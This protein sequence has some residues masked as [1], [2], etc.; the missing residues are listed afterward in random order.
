MNSWAWLLVELLSVLVFAQTVIWL[1]NAKYRGPRGRLRIRQILSR[2]KLEANGFNVGQ[3]QGDPEKDGLK[4]GEYYEGEVD[5]YPV[6]ISFKPSTGWIEHP[7]YIVRVCLAVFGGGA[8]SNT[9]V[10]N[11]EAYDWVES[12]MIVGKF[13]HPSGERLIDVARELI[14]DANRKAG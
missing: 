10:T 9:V 8:S 6:E 3:T 11:S 12:Q 2:L 1:N 13:S 14:S 4:P 5:G 7:Y